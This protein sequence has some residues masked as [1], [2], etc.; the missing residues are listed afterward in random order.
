MHGLGLGGI[1]DHCV[2]A[3]TS[4][5]VPFSWETFGLRHQDFIS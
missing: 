2:L 3:R 1:D 5:G 4:P